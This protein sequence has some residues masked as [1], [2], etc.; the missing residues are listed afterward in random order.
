[1]SSTTIPHQEFYFIRHG[2]TDWNKELRLM[3]QTDI[4]LNNHGIAQAQHA[5]RILE[6]ISFTSIIASPLDRA[7]T[8]AR[9]IAE[10]TKKQIT[11]IPD[12]QEVF[13]GPLQG[14]YK[15]DYPAALIQQW[16]DGTLQN[17]ESFQNFTQR[18]LRALA[19][20]LTLPDPVLIVSHG[21]VYR[22]IQ[23]ALLQSSSE[24]TSNCVIIKY[25]PPPLAGFPW[26]SATL[27]E[28]L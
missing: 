7:A 1:M 16:L 21:G 20:T 24:G 13:L 9:I 3:G 23:K 8:T 26:H 10:K 22:V 12:F 11:I 15:K 17:T 14:M 5:A 4:P 6:T 25:T 28:C 2:E 18:V 19:H 27:N